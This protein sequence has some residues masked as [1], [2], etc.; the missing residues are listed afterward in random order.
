MIHEAMVLEYAGRH[1][2]MIELAA[3]L[4]LLLYVSLLACIFTPWGMAAASAGFSAYL[5]GVAIYVAKLTVAGFLLAVFE[6]GIAKMRIF[7]VD[8]FLGV[9]LML[10][11]LGTLLLFVSRSL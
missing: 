1:L 2:A 5:I 9:A 4:K 10:G 8:E 7:R 11:L 3:A 6:T